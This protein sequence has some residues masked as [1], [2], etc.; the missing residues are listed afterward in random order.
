MSHKEIIAVV[1]DLI[2]LVLLYRIWIDGRAIRAI[3]AAS[4]NLYIRYF[5][6]RTEERR[7]KLEQ[8]AM[9]RAAKAAK[10]TEATP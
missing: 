6:E 8:L 10:K 9:A 7:K 3:E 1:R 2:E 5:E 4:H